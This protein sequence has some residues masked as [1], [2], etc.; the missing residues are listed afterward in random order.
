MKKN[1]KKDPPT[2]SQSHQSSDNTIAIVG[3]VVPVVI[4][5]TIAIAVAVIAIV[6]FTQKNRKA[7]LVF[8]KERLK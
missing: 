4:V 8:Q 6:L 2:P 1:Q 7:E 5:V 3:G